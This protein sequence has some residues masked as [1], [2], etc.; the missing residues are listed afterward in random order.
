M[1]RAARDID[2]RQAGAGAPARPERAAG[3]GAVILQ[4]AGVRG[5]GIGGGKTAEGRAGADGDAGFSLFRE[6]AA[7]I[8]QRALRSRQPVEFARAVGAAQD[9]ALDA[10]DVEFFRAAFDARENVQNLVAA[11]LAEAWMPDQVEAEAFRL[12]EKAG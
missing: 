6:R 9:R 10:E 1:R 4:A 11:G 12:R 8:E 3:L 7:E 5:V 2:H